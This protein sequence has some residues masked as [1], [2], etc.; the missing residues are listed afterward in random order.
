MSANKEVV[1]RYFEALRRLDRDAMLACVTDDIER[2]E[3]A[4]GFSTSGVPIRG[5]PAFRQ[6]ISDPPGPGG[7]RIEVSRMTEENNVVVAEATVRVPMKDGSLLAVKAWNVFQFVDGRIRR[8]DAM[9]VLTK[10]PP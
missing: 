5:K 10:D 7:L 3:W 9:T 1:G 2:V 8:V 4:D 6:S